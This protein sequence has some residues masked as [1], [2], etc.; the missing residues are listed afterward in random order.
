MS[1]SENK[2]VFVKNDDNASE[3]IAAP[4]YSYW[5]AVFKKFLSSKST[6]IVL[7]IAL[8]VI[9]LSIIDPMISNY[10]GIT[11]VNINDTSMQFIHP[12][13]KYFFGT[14]D[15]GDNL[16]NVVWIG[17]R[18]S[19]A[20]AGITT[21]ITIVLGVVVGAIWGYS[22]KMDKWMIEIYN[23]IANVP[24]TLVVFVL[25]YVLGRGFWQLIFAMSVTSWLSTA[26]FIRTQVM[27][28]RDREYNLASQCLGTSTW[29][30]VK[31]NIMPFL[32]SIIV[33]SISRDMPSYISLEV[34][35]AWLGIGVGETT[36][37]LGKT[38]SANRTF[39]TSTPYLFWIPVAISAVITISLY[40]AGQTF[41]DAADPRTHM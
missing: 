15:Y 20:I 37:S 41:A 7:I 14:N 29:T 27:I 33:T 26:Y 4:K 28:I 35:L 21:L 18:N 2:F 6:V 8:T 13:L 3:H 24:F 38:I 19:L 32:V 40:V 25:M 22:K 34:F 16:W 31:N 11:H 30:I 12:S 10:D 9:A 5:S 36:P 39:M 1:E 17:A 23:I